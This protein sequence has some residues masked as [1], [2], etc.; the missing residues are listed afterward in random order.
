MLEIRGWQGSKDIYQWALNDD[1]FGPRIRPI[2]TVD[3][4]LHRAIGRG[5]LKMHPTRHTPN[6]F[7]FTQTGGFPILSQAFVGF[8]PLAS[9]PLG[10]VTQAVDGQGR[11]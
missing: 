2:N 9:F 5:R 1:K 3:T 10:R 8:L 11:P 7:V 4:R 6:D